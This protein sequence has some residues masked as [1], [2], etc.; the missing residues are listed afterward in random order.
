MDAET[1]GDVDANLA[2]AVGLIALGG[3]SPAEAAETAGVSRWELE[4]AVQAAGL[5]EPLGIGDRCDVAAE[6]DE[7]LDDGP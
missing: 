7:L 3:A 5:A 6:I 4:T 1:G 2:L